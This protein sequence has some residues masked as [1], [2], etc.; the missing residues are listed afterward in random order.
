M[1]VCAFVTLCTGKLNVAPAC[2]A[3]LSGYIE[4]ILQSVSFTKHYIAH[5]SLSSMLLLVHFSPTLMQ[6]VVAVFFLSQ[7]MLV[8][9]VGVFNE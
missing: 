9:C 1:F 5:R 2:S 6:C 4:D 3:L 7:S 8:D